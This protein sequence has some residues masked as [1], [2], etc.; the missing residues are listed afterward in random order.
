MAFNVE[1]LTA[2]DRL[3]YNTD[4][5]MM[6]LSKIPLKSWIID[7]ERDISIWGGMFA[8]HWMAL[9][10]LEDYRWSFNLRFQKK[11][12]KFIIFPSDG[13]KKLTEDPYIVCWSSIYGVL[14]QDLHGFL[15]DDV[16]SVFK[17]ALI[18]YSIFE[19]KE[20]IKGEI[21]VKIGF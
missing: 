5:E 16:L 2:E 12:F 6:D 17:E 1:M 9:A 7:K 15:F 13:S 11:L 14:P 20:Y 4:P 8:S 3:R 10:E 21:I 18:A 19:K